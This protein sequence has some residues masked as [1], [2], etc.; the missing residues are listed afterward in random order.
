MGLI[1]AFWA[2]LGPDRTC[3]CV[4]S[5]TASRGGG[6]DLLLLVAVVVLAG[7]YLSSA[8]LICHGDPVICWFLGVR[9]RMPGR[10]PWK[11]DDTGVSAASDVA[12]VMA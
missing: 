7:L 11:V 6:Y 2:D 10:R 3:C 1:W 4:R 8:S 5:V 12:V 9:L